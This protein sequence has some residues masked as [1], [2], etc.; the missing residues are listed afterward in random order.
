MGQLQ[1]ELLERG[2]GD[3]ENTFLAGIHGR[4]SRCGQ[5][6]CFCYMLTEKGVHIVGDR[7]VCYGE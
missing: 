5:E 4:G 6:S 3:R 1:G 2:E 7:R